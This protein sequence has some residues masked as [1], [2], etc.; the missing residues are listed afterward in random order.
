MRIS[1]STRLALTPCVASYR[2][3]DISSAGTAIISQKL[4]SVIRV[5]NVDNGAGRPGAGL[6]FI[7]IVVLMSLRRQLRDFVEHPLPSPCSLLFQPGHISGRWTFGCLS[8]AR[9]ILCYNSD[10]FQKLRTCNYTTLDSLPPEWG[11]GGQPSCVCVG[12][13]FAYWRWATNGFTN[14]CN[15]CP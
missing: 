2:A 7:V 5:P 1:D 8:S 14:D 9:F 13:I 11:R 10:F 4:F 12:V 6:C 3:W 15:R